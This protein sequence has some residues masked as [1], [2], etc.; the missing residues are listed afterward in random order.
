MKKLDLTQILKDAPKG[1]KL[2]S[3]L[4]GEVTL[5]EITTEVIEYHVKIDTTDEYVSFTSEGHYFSGYP[6]SECLLF[7]SKSQRDWDKFVIED[8]FEKGEL[9][10]VKDNIKDSPWIAAFYSHRE[11]NQYMCF[12]NQQKA[13]ETMPWDKCVKFEKRPF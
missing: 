1:T 6:D 10:W 5:N 4:F 8:T 12:D 3:P 9:V 7:P 2:W 13:G 11:G